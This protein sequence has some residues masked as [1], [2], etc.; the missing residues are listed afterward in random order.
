MQS[1]KK[2]DLK[3]AIING[4]MTLVIVYLTLAMILFVYPLLSLVQLMTERVTLG[5]VLRAYAQDVKF[6]VIE[7]FE[8]ICLTWADDVDGA[9]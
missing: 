4:F 6:A 7:N 2:S 8:S 9:E 5:F 3:G 1:V